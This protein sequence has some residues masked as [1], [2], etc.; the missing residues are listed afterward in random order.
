MAFDTDKQV[1]ELSIN[2]TYERYSYNKKILEI[3][4]QKIEE[5]P[6]LRFGQIL[7]ALKI[8][9]YVTDYNDDGSPVTKDPFYIE[10][11]DMWE[12]MTK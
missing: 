11:K 6:E 1:D 4:E 2:L 8:V 5:N 7:C 12:N 10:S 3:L 9:T